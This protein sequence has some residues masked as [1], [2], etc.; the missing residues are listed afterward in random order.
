MGYN[1]SLK[2]RNQAASQNHFDMVAGIVN[3]MSDCF[4][5]AADVCFKSLRSQRPNKA[6]ALFA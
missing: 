1:G 2:E 5:F 6:L 4:A 3:R